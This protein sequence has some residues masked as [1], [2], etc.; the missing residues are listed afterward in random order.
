MLAQGVQLVGPESFVMPKPIMDSSQ[1]ARLQG[2]KPLPPRLARLDQPRFAQDPQVMRNGRLTD[3]KT[4]HQFA[5][6]AFS[7]GQQVK[8]GTARRFTY[9]LEHRIGSHGSRYYIND[10]LCVNQ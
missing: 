10:C 9:R 1:R 6:G 4:A 7:A 2:I 5:H 3:I 8:H